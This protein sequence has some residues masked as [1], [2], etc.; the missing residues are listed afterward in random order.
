MSDLDPTTGRKTAT[1]KRMHFRTAIDFYTNDK[2]AHVADPVERLAVR[3]LLGHSI[4]MSRRNGSDGHIVPEQALAELDLPPE[5]G[6]ILIADGAWHQADHGCRRCPE[7]RFGHV[8]VHD[9]LEHNHSAE[10]ERRSAERARRNGAAGGA[11]RWAGHT[12]EEKPKRGPGRPRKHPLPDPATIVHPA[13]LLAGQKRRGRPAKTEPRVYPP[14]VDEL[15]AELAA[16]VRENGFTVT[17]QQQVSVGWREAVRLMLE[18]DGRSERQIRNMIA[19]CQDDFFWYKNIHAMPK[20]RQKYERMREDTKDPTRD[21][22]RR[23]GGKVTGPAF[24]SKRLGQP[25]RPG[26]PP[27]AVSVTGMNG[28]LAAQMRARQEGMVKGGN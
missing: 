5:M 27:A 2:L 17:N 18:K 20:L 24:N 7:P 9:I 1:D 23:T 6:K 12:P 11:A 3:G 15:C 8:Y 26:Q 10:Q 4:A 14:I 25:G 22:V 21:K 28:M 16:R 13:E 19:W